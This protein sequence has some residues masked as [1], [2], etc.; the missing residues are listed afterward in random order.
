[1]KQAWGEK[2]EGMR[3][4]GQ[5]RGKW[6]DNIKMGPKEVGWKSLDWI[7]LAQDRDHWRVLVNM[8]IHLWVQ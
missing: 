5:P 6:E 7:H 1:M 3:P 2:P 4:L 8:V